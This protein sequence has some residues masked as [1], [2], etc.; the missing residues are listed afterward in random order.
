MSFG[1]SHR[2]WRLL[3]FTETER[4]AFCFDFLPPSGKGHFGLWYLARSSIIWDPLVYD[5][6]FLMKVTRFTALD[7]WP[8]SWMWV[9]SGISQYRGIQHSLSRQDS[10]P[11]IILLT[12]FR[13]GL[14]PTPLPNYIFS[15]LGLC[16][17][18]C[19]TPRLTC[20][21]TVSTWEIGN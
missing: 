16:N 1:L 20:K 8:L 2:V 4:L 21:D 18:P 6:R 14:S 13:N 7:F 5:N 19:T 15:F 17:P 12:W 3:P 10:K 9:Q 11:K